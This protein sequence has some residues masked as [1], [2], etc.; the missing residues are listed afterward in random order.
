MNYRATCPHC[1][2]VFRVG[3]EQLA[4]ANGWVQCGV[5]GAAFDARLSL[6]MADGANL[7]I[8]AEA[9]AHPAR[10]VSP[11]AESPSESPALGATADPQTPSAPEPVISFPDQAGSKDASDLPPIILI[12]PES[13]NHDAPDALPAS[14]V[15]AVPVRTKAADS[16][17]S[18]APSA[19]IEHARS[20]AF[21]AR[22]APRRRLKPWIGGLAAVLLLLTLAAQL[23]W[24][25]RDPLYTAFPAIRPLVERAC[26][27]MGCTLSPP[28]QLDHL[29]IVGSELTT[30]TGGDLRLTLTLGNRAPHAMAWPVLV[31]TLTDQTGQAL[32]RRSF[33]PSEYLAD[34]AR[35]A[36]GMPPLS[37]QPLSLPLAIRDLAPVGF[38]LELRY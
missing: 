2:S 34:P 37:E 38:E 20:T 19:R 15:E 10:P 32:A 9:D 3:D 7:P 28:K 1:V 6:R 29:R 13:P 31:L 36:A 21:P 14:P 8:V 30:E 33:A 35:I 27:S 16:P 22:R 24:F 26:L 25:L 17:S 11:C 5:C 18:P 4:A 23:A 12:E